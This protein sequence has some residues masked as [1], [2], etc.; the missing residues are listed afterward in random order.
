VGYELNGENEKKVFNG[1]F[2]QDVELVICTAGSYD[3]R[4]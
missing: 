4:R 2:F 1:Q 3:L